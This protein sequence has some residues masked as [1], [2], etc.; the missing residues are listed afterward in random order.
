ML[1]WLSEDSEE[2]LNKWIS[3]ANHYKGDERNFLIFD[4]FDIMVV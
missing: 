4:V 2:Y 3:I 1:T